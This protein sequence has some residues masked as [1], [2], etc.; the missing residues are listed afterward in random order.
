MDPSLL[1][2]TYTHLVFWDPTLDLENKLIPV[3][4]KI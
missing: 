4:V 2:Q 1:P 3:G